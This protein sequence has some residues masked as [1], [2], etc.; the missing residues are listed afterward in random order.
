MENCAS[1]KDVTLCG[2][3]QGSV[4]GP[5][6]FLI[7]INDI[8]ESPKIFKFFSF[9]DNTNLLYA[10]KDLKILETVV[11]I[12]LTKVCDWL[13]IKKLTPNIKMIIMKQKWLL[14]IIYI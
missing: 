10:E 5:L 1:E 3:P 13:I 6:V 8:C 12:E 2:V 9:A 7:Y 4:F 14:M 11:N